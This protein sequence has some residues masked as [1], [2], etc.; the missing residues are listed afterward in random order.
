[1]ETLTGVAAESGQAVKG[2]AKRFFQI[3][4]EAAWEIPAGHGG[5][6]FF[7]GEKM[8]VYKDPEGIIHPVDIRCPHL[9]C[10][11]EWDPDEKTWDCPCHGSRYDVTGKILN[12]PAL[13]P[14]GKTTLGEEQGK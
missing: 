13:E 1:M 10:Q 4:A 9:G 2:L 14:L 5:I 7:H 12:N 8:G 6:V 3:P 11:L